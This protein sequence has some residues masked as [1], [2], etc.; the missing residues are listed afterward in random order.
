MQIRNGRRII[1][2]KRTKAKAKATKDVV[3][4]VVVDAATKEDAV[5][6]AVVKVVA[7]DKV[8]ETM[9]DADSMKE[10]I[11]GKIV[12]PTGRAQLE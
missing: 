10:H 2:R 6:D 4:V 3:V 11:F 12:H 8:E 5:V 9:S 1:K 7:V